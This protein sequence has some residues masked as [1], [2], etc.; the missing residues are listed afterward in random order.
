MTKRGLR[1]AISEFLLALLSRILVMPLGWLVPR[2]AGL[3]VVLGREHGRY[4]DN[5]KYFHAW[6]HG[7]LPTEQRVVF[8]GERCDE[9]ERVAAAGANVAHYPGWRACS[10]LLRAGT[11]VCD[12]ADVVEHGRIG[13]IAGACRLQIWHG[14]PLKEIELPLHRRRLES[15]SAPLRAALRFQKAVL[16]RYEPWDVLVSTSSYLTQQAFKA[17][18]PAYSIL[19][20]GYPRND[21]LSGADG[22]PPALLDVNVDREV[23]QR[24][25]AHRAAGG[26]VVLYAPTFRADGGSPF[27]GGHIDLAGLSRF[28]ERQNVLFALKLHPVMTGRYSVDTH[29]GVVEISAASDVYPLL[30]L[31]D[32]LI[33]DYSSIFFDYLL[34]DRPLV[35]YPYDLATYVADDRRLLFD[36]EKITPGPKAQDFVELL[37]V[38]DRVLAAGADVWAIQRQHV[39]RLVFDHEGC[40]AARRLWEALAGAGR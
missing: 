31:V 21:A 26:R 34:L 17:S 7:N 40:G 9:L 11:V 10:L 2:D 24:L 27:A 5:A 18:L 4:L 6:L 30:P 3:W 23:A 37:T 29:P 36:Y 28:A 1:I 13:F 15:M 8:I 19:V 33:T 14:V 12:S 22:Y 25:E 39:R 35:F 20:S 38:V 16:G 32:L